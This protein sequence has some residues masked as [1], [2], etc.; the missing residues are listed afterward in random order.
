MKN[1]SQ[2]QY[3]QKVFLEGVKLKGVTSVDGSY[4]HSVK[5]INVL[6]QGAVKTVF[7]DVPQADFSISRNM[8]F[9]DIFN[10]FTGVVSKLRG[11][12]NYGNK[13]FGFENGYLSSYSYGVSYGDVPQ[14]NIGIKVYGDIGSG[15]YLSN[16]SN[17][18]FVGIDGTLNATGDYNDADDLPIYP[19]NISLTCRNSTT[20]RIKSFSFST[21]IDYH[22]IYG[23]NSTLPL[24]VSIKYPIEVLVDFTIEV[25]DYETKRMTDML[26]TGSAD[27]FTINVFG[28][29]FE[30][31][32]IY[33]TTFTSNGPLLT[34]LQAG[35]GTPLLF[36]R[37]PSSNA[38]SNSTG[39]TGP[40]SGPSYD[41]NYVKLF[42]FSYSPETSK[43]VSEQISASADDVSTVKLSYVTYVNKTSKNSD[44]FDNQ[45]KNNK[46]KYSSTLQAFQ[47]QNK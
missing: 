36:R 20:N 15:M 8:A 3:D 1:K 34:P 43:L 25:D 24:Q 33:T 6:G 47:Q 38:Y 4:S 22:V 18:Q 12:L 32:N 9:A 7:A 30:D 26:V 2:A 42:T 44:I 11:S 45:F 17:P 35:D 19:A 13:V 10:P 40:V 28:T 37:K 5:P 41:Y 14:T 21:N 31:Q 39:P 23:M 16:S 46:I 27:P 29:V